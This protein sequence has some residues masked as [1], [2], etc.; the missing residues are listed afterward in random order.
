MK[1]KISGKTFTNFSS[2]EINLIFNSVASTFSFDT[3]SDELKDLINFQQCEIFTDDNDLLITGTILP[4][5]LRSSTVKETVKVKGYSLPG[6]LEDCQ[7]PVTLYPLQFD[8]LNLKEITEKILSIF[9][10][11]FQFSSSVAEIINKK[12][13]KIESDPKKT[14]KEFLNELARQRNIILSHLPDGRLLYTKFAASLRTVDH[15]EIGMN[16]IEKMAIQINGQ[17]LHNPIYVVGQSGSDENSD[18]T[19]AVIDNPYFEA[20][21][22]KVIV[23]SDGDEFDAETTARN[24]LAKEVSSIKLTF[25]TTKF[26]KPGR[27]ITVKN[28]EIRL[29][30]ATP[31]FIESVNIKGSSN[32]KDKYNYTCVPRAVYTDESVTNIFK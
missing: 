2:Y 25:Q 19:D 22:P 26:N 5:T 30:K 6:V 17:K 21:R 28:P 9:P 14:I 15:F 27:L 29:N 31:F 8:G 10:F 1:L 23:L 11:S 16:G 20:F 12:Y 4:T 13:E 3:Q 7:I 24:E 18:S 32:E